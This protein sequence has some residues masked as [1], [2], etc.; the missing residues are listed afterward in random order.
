MQQ[1]QRILY[2]T[3][4]SERATAAFPLACALARDHG[5][6]LLVLHVK[7]PVVIVGV[8][9][10]PEP[11]ELRQQ[12]HEQLNRLRP[13]DPNV[14]VEHQLLEGEPAREILRLAREANCD[15]IV[16]GT[17]GR[18][19]LPRLLLGSVAE[20]VMRKA[21]CPVLTVKVPVVEAARAEL[22][23]APGR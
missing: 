16:M 4:F 19:G 22:A 14:R 13:A 11:P 17:H 6:Q 7:P 12:L 5:A 18:T 10:A 9:V 23:A 20:E 2:P 3:D 21:A 15:L 1:I 8:L